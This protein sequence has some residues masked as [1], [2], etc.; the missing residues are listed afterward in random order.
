MF[1]IIAVFTLFFSLISNIEINASGNSYISKIEGNEHNEHEVTQA[2]GTVNDYSE[3]IYV[4]TGIK[5][6]A[7]ENNGNEY[8]GTDI[9]VDANS[10]FVNFEG[11]LQ[12][13][14]PDEAHILMV[15]QY[16]FQII[17]SLGNIVWYINY[18]YEQDQD[19]TTLYRI[20]V[21]INGDSYMESN[22]D[23]GVAVMSFL[24]SRFGNQLISLTDGNYTIKITRE[25]WWMNQFSNVFQ[26]KAYVSNTL[27]EASLTI[28]STPPVITV[29]GVNDNSTITSGSYINQ[30]VKFTISD[31][32]FSNFY[33]KKSG[34]SSFT[35]TTSSTYTTDSS[36]GWWTVYAK[37]TFGNKSS[38][39]TFYY[40]NTIPVGSI[41]SNGSNVTNGSYISKSFY[42]TVTDT[43]SG[44]KNIYSKT[45]VSGNYESY[46]SGTIIPASAGDGWYYFYAVDKAGNTS[47]TMK[48]YL[49][50]QAPVVKIYRN[51]NVA[52][53]TTITGEGTFDSDVYLKKKDVFKITYES[54]SGIVNCNYTLN[55]D[56]TI[57]DSYTNST[58]VVTVQTVTGVTVNYTIHLVD[59]EP[60]MKIGD[61]IYKSG[62]TL[63]LNKDTTV[64]WFDDLDI[65]NSGN[66]GVI[67][68]STGNN[69]I[70]ETYKYSDYTNTTISTGSNTET[71]YA[72]TLNDRVD[73]VSTYT[74][75]LDKKPVSAVWV[76]NNLQIDNN[77][78]TN[79]SVTLLYEEENVT[80]TYSK[81]TGESKNYSL[82]TNFEED[83]TYSV[84]LSDI[85]GNKSSYSINIEK[86]IPVGQ[87][88]INE[89]SVENGS[90]T[91]NNFKYIATDENSGIEYVYYKTPTGGDY[92]KYVSGTII[93]NNSGDGWYYFYAVDK[94]GNS[95]VEYSIY[96]EYKEPKVAIYRN[97]VIS[98]NTTISDSGTFDTDIYFNKNDSFKV[99]YE[100]SSNVVVSNYELNKNITI[101]DSY[102]NSQYQIIIETPTGLTAKYIIHIIDQKPYITIDDVIYNSDSTIYLN[103]DSFVYWFDDSD[104]I[105]SSDTG[106]TINSTGSTTINE[107]YKY[108]EEGG[109]NLTTKDN[110][111]TLYTITLT[112]RADNISIFNIYIDKKPVSAVWKTI[113]TTIENNGFINKDAY[114]FYEEDNVNALYS[115]NI[116]E[117]EIYLE[118]QQFSEDGTYNVVLTDLANNQSTYTITIDKINPTGQLYVN[119]A[120]IESGSYTLNNFAYFANDENSG[121]DYV[122]YKTPTGGDFQKYVS[123]NIIS[124]N[125]GDGWYYFYTIDKAG[126]TSETLSIYLEKEI[127]TIEIYK[128]DIVLYNVNV[129]ENGTFDTDIY[130]KKEDNFKITYESSSNVVESN[131]E[132]NTNITI[133]DSY[134]NSQ[135]QVCI[136]TPTGIEVNYTI[137]IVDQ[138]PYITIEDKTYNDGSTIYLNK[139]SV[140][141]WFDDPDIINS[142]NTGIGITSTG[143][144]NINESY[145]YLEK[146]NI[147]LST[148]SNTETIYTLTLNDRVDNV[149]TYTI[150]LDKK[151][152]EG[153]W[154]TD[155]GVVANKSHV[156]RKVRLLYEDVGSATY[157]KDGEEYQEY[158]NESEF[159]VDGTYNIALIDLAGNKSNYSITIDTISP[160]GQFLANYQIVENNSITKEKVIFSWDGENT[161]TVNNNE[162]LKNTVITE[163]GIYNFV[164]TDL[165][166]NSSEYSIEIDTKAPT[167]NFENIS[168]SKNYKVGKWYDVTFNEIKKSFGNYETALEYA[169]LIEF[170]NYVSV[171]ELNNV[172]D[173]TQY[174]L[175][176]SKGNPQ[177]DIRVGTYWRYKSQFRPTDEL[178]YFDESLLNEVVR[179]YASNYVSQAN[180]FNLNQNTYGELSDD[181][182][183]NICIVDINTK[184][185]CINGYSFEK[186]DS[187]EIYVEIDGDEESK[188]V[189][190]FNK[191]IDEQITVTGLY[192]ITEID[193]AGNI[194]TYHVYFDKE[195]PSVIVNSEIFVEGETKEIKI[196]NNSISDINTYYYKIF[197]FKSILDSD[198]W[199]T[200]SIT[201]DGTTTY[202]SKG[203]TLPM[204]N[205]GGKYEV[206][207]YDRFKNNYSFVVYIVGNEASITFTPNQEMTEFNISISLEQE[208]DIVVSLEI[209][210][211]DIRIEETSTKVLNYTF[212]KD[213]IYKVILRDNFG[214]VIEKIYDFNKSL[215]IGNLS[216]E[217][218]SRTIDEVNFTFDST[219]YIAEI[220][221]NEN[222]TNTNIT[223]EIKAVS[224]GDYEIKL[225]NLTDEENINL[226]TF[227]IDTKAPQINISGCE[228]GQTTNTDV[229]ISW[230]DTDV[231]K[232]IYIFNNGEE[233]IIEKGSVFIEEGHYEIKV[234]DDLG[235]ESIITFTIDKSIDYQIYVNNAETTGI[236]VT[237]QD[238]SII[239]NEE[240]SASIVRNN[241]AYEYAF[242]SVISKEGVYQIRLADAYGNTTTFTII[243]DKSVDVYATTGDGVISN[244]EVIVSAGE[245]VTTIVTK[246]GQ[247]YQF[248]IGQAI[249]EEGKYKFNVY[250]TFG[251]EKSFSFEIV[252]GT[253][254][255]LDYALGESVEIISITK[256]EEI[257]EWDSNTLNFNE[258]GTYLISCKVDNEEYN[259]E[260]SLD[261]TAPEV[262]LNGIENGGVDNTTVTITDMTEEGIIEVY[263]DGILVEY[264]L[265]NEIKEYGSYEVKVSDALGNN[266]TYTF[267]LEYQMNGWAIALIV[268]GIIAVVGVIIIVYWKKK[269]VFKK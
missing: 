113:D 68:K 52:Y 175:V 171:L 228:N 42:Y 202:Y 233:L 239:N 36:T 251:N 99:I 28:D 65:T 35:S 249:S 158:I 132:L 8:S 242:G 259:F 191:N 46:T 212:I 145:K 152:I 186:V 124:A 30:N 7:S 210:K 248:T 261:T 130:L 126:N 188:I 20:Y 5:I 21:D 122:Y 17:N 156:N 151:P 260:L 98:Y 258:D 87:I 40:D 222:I 265:G 211:D 105:N 232:A 78:Y 220:T 214:R 236:E 229:S 57:D 90:Y 216:I 217:N 41:S 179:E 199:A 23:S 74:I 19:N 1:V 234:S 140:V 221:I 29:K 18:Y 15:N 138:K 123:G 178:Y 143:N 92:Q 157:S 139:D 9:K 13:Y 70:N 204:L 43:L 47:E 170:E 73:N 25:Y 177:D 208:F 230:E 12:F 82:G 203:D 235:N 207:I 2:Y 85:A 104:I 247:P 266:R 205:V 135:Y 109:K 119:D 93:S 238:V 185:P 197:E 50:N 237:S 226:Y 189:I 24:P 127:P 48:V 196:D 55:K 163:D 215:P 159:S 137:H 3:D 213:G 79:K 168:N 71:I 174:H 10:F 250:D 116:N 22:E 107:S 243:I 31:T 128:N 34:S 223:G 245:K 240:L 89:V 81:D 252:K 254:T 184:V 84:T 164:L 106:V 244:N 192:K 97:N 120:I 246:D 181:M 108:S 231:V 91:L 150:Y 76:S 114:L 14:R 224:D 96:L 121:I 115:K 61:I 144:N 201:K 146:D 63:Y 102:I 154:L 72:L 88:Y 180:Y 264:T 53:S 11:S 26:M 253:K 148:E 172:N 190:D 134:I 162:Y 149:S 141:Y 153:I 131:Y 95:S 67:I 38:E 257:I 58:F 255:M 173:F 62:A 194:A 39:F 167:Y 161:A 256:N 80:A 54:S 133:D 183:D 112:D 268:I 56:I 129:I 218:G 155:E 225:I 209:Y 16:D 227:T 169:S 136:K 33:Y 269:R 160:I 206:L 37:D 166:G 198:Q 101:D 200:I 219:K 44:I 6:Y 51:G 110:S 27:T 263:K 49:E 241:E 32:H 262:T 59:E 45:P 147:T 182:Y 103:K 86:V 176:A 75:Y 83:G 165:A 66:T 4:D 267:V 142:A 111:E 125:S 117:Y 64:Y 100:S 77:S 195:A 69:V 94:A 60:Y 118:N 187:H 193:E